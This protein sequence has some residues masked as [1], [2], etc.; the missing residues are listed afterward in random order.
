MAGVNVAMGTPLTAAFL[1]S[2]AITKDYLVVFG[3]DDETV[4][5]SSSTD[6][7]LVIGTAAFTISTADVSA[8]KTVDVNLL[9]SRIVMMVAGGTVTRG[10]RQAAAATDGTITDVGA[11]PDPGAVLGIAMKSGVSGDFIPVLIP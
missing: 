10:T 11:S 5:L 7:E 2:A 8:G 1:A 4:T 9:G 6:S 3:I